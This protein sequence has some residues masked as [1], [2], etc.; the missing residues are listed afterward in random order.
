MNY[1]TWNRQ[2]KLRFLLAEIVL[3]LMLF[4]FGLVS[5]VSAQTIFES[6]YFADNFPDITT[7]NTNNADFGPIQID[8]W[9][10]SSGQYAPIATGTITNAL[11]PLRWVPFGSFDGSSSHEVILY[12]NNNPVDCRTA[13]F[14]PNQVA[15]SGVPTWVNF[16]F[17]GTEC[18]IYDFPRDC[19]TC[20]PF[21]N[22]PSFSWDFN[23]LPGTSGA[24]GSRNFNGFTPY[25]VYGEQGPTN[26]DLLV[27]DEVVVSPIDFNTRFTNATAQGN[28]STTIS[29]DVDY[30][31]DTSEYTANTRPDYININILADGF[32]NDQQV[33][34]AQ[35]LI[36]PLTN[37]AQSTLVPID[38][39]FPDGN[40]LA[41]GS[42]WNINSQAI[43]FEQTG[44][45]VSFEVLNGSVV[46][47]ELTE[48]YDGLNLSE[49]IQYEDCTLTNIDGCLRNALIY[50]FV[51]TEGSF[52]RFVTLYERIETK[53]PFGYVTAVRNGLSGLGGSTTPAF[54]FGQLPFVGTIFE[55]FKALL[56]IGFFVIYALFFMGRLDRL[57]I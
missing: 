14:V 18:E 54:D 25:L 30:E 49:S 31:L 8:Q 9:A 41:Y 6:P 53:P 27:P 13:P 34:L 46:N 45:V 32:L 51:P 2:K 5:I 12:M 17:S 4:G 10:T 11:V 33:A 36:L 47:S 52:D 57:D 16:E 15:S 56:T 1:R 43:T 55:P 20:N 3:V 35:K 24:I 44:F 23:V 42:F 38:Y 50:T 39:A 40:Y 7:L 48:I 28:S 21:I 29:I 22:E 37:G 26:P 19:V